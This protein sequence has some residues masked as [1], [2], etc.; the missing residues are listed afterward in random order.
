MQCPV[1]FAQ[2][3]QKSPT[4][5][6]V[7]F[8]NATAKRALEFH[9]HGLW[10]KAIDLE[11]LEIFTFHDAGWANALPREN[12]DDSDFTLSAEDH[13]RGAIRNTLF[14][15]KERKAK[16]A[17]SKVA[18]QFGVLTVLGDSRCYRPEGGPVSIL[19]WRSSAIQRVC[20]STFTAETMAC[21]EGVETGQYLRS[22]IHSLM[23]GKLL[24]VEELK[25]R[26]VR[27]YS[28]CKSLY[29]HLHKEGAPRTPSDKRLAIDL[30]ALR[31]SLH[32]ERRDTRLPLHWL[33]THRQLA[34]VLTKP[35]NPE[36]W[37]K[38][39]EGDISMPLHSLVH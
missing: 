6:D 20:R 22:Y 34:D 4:V 26:C 36:A 12:E 25:G 24:R 1:S 2:Q 13:E 33:P 27:F 35:L 7:K 23:S 9:E 16:K 17:S 14:D 37:W 32:S 15:A 38:A 18:S 31:Q 3:L 39:V 30:A 28:D 11:S 5:E 21:T 8:T 19:D 10:L 29:D